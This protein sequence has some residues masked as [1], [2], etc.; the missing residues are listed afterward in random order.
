MKPTTK[1]WS[2][3]ES[4]DSLPADM[5]TNRPR[6]RSWAFKN[7]WP[8]A[9]LVLALSTSFFLWGFLAHRQKLFPY[10]WI[11]SAAHSLGLVDKSIGTQRTR[12]YGKENRAEQLTALPYAER[13][14]DPE[15]D[16]RGVT[17]HD[18]AQVFQGLNFY[19]SQDLPAAFLL[20]MEGHLV[21]QWR[22]RGE[23]WDH[24]TLLPTGEVIALVGGQALHK[25]SL[26]SEIVWTYEGGF[27]HDVWL[28]DDGRVFS[29]TH[30][31]EWVPSLHESQPILV[32][33][34]TVLSPDGTLLE[35]I[36]ILE[37]FQNSAHAHLLPS[38]GYRTWT[39]SGEEPSDVAL[40]ILHT[41]HIEVLDGSLE[42]FFRWYEKGNVLLSMRHL[43]T[44]AIADLEAREIVWAWGSTT[45]SLPHHP[46]VLENGNLL[47]FNN[48]TDQ[49]A[50]LELDPRTRDVV[51][52]Y[53]DDPEFFT[54]TRGSSL[55]LPNGNT[56][57]TESDP[58]YVF[59]VTPKGEKVW[60]FA[61]PRINDEN[62]RAAIW[63]MFR[64]TPEQLPFL[65][66][67]PER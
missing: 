48:G 43:D 47:L 9:L 56:L 38:I 44:I 35:E 30:R 57:I 58:G 18:P 8:T 51:W 49:S 61:N 11:R 2:L 26:D 64:F 27:H 65:A 15:G 10:A 29:L 60:V 40:D 45:L 17:L 59:E 41:N 33:Y 6:A 5:K 4:R 52:F 25:V 66:E 54:P 32:D 14:Y 22:H 1:A 3:L 31:A 46:T 28:P 24:V 55:R 67:I 42:S 53:G 34:I 21:H 7:R 12:I 19:S 39:K 20:D 36:S 62:E 23:A 37:L 16:R 63:R 50:V 13:T